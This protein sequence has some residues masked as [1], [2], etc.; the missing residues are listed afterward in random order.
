VTEENTTKTDQPVV[1]KKAESLVDILK[2]KELHYISHKLIGGD[3]RITLACADREK[4]MDKGRAY[5]VNDVPREVPTL[6]SFA[7][8]GVTFDG[9]I[10]SFDANIGIDAVDIPADLDARNAAAWRYRQ[11]YRVTKGI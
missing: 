1:E 9:S 5:C 6:A 4:L 3:V 7:G 11:T 10:T 8:A 2:D